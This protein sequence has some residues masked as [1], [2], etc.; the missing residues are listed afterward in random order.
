MWIMLIAT[1]VP[2]LTRS[3]A[4]V[5]CRSPGWEHAPPRA[6]QE[7]SEDIQMLALQVLAVLVTV[8]NHDQSRPS[9]IKQVPASRP[10][11]CKKWQAR[12]NRDQALKCKHRPRQHRH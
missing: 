12:N 6:G 10:P 2:Y 7:S 1:V 11:I 4:P 9:G 5:K 8:D 3:L